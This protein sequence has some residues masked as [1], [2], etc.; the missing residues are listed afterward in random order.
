MR[1]PL[2]ATRRTLQRFRQS[3]S[4]STAAEFAIAVTIAIGLI[5]AVVDVSRA[6]I[7]GGLLSDS[8]RQVSRQNQ[9]KET[10]YSNAAFAIAANATIAA[11]SSGMLDSSQVAISTTVYDSFE[12]LANNTPVGGGPPGGRPDQ[13]VKYRFTY[14][15]DYYTPFVGLMMEGAEFNHVVEIIVYNEPDVES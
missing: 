6:F 2:F 13:I 10:P 7:V 12:D 4:G 3:E 8:A 5:F 11:R 9:V 14:D 15:M 1:A